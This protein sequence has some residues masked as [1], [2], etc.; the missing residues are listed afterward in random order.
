M[1]MNKIALAAALAF[2]GVAAHADITIGNERNSLTFY[3]VLD[4]GL[5]TTNHSL[6]EDPNSAS[7]N[8][9]MANAAPSLHRLTSFLP[10]NT[11]P[12][13]WG[14]KGQRNFDGGDSAGFVLESMINVNTG[15][16]PNGR[17]SDSLPGAGSMFNKGE[18]SIQGQMFDREASVW[19]KNDQYG[20]FKFGHMTTLMG[21][22]QFGYD[23]MSVGYAVSPLG[24]NGGW[25]A[26]A[27]TGD[28][29][30]DNSV[31]WTNSYGPFQAGLQYKFGGYTQGFTMGTAESAKIAYETAPFGVSLNVQ[32]TLDTL[33]VGGSTSTTACAAS[34]TLSCATPMSPNALSVSVANARAVALM[35]RYELSAQATLKG[36]F[37]QIHLQ[38]PTNAGSY[39]V[40]NIGQLS[41]LP[42]NSINIAPFAA[43]TGSLTQRMLWAGVNYKVDAKST[44]SAAYYRRTDDY[45]M[46][47][48]NNANYLSGKYEY[49]VDKDTTLY[50]TGVT[51]SVGT[52]VNVPT[53][54][55]GATWYQAAYHGLIP[56]TTT[57]TVGGVYRF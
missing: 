18:G 45:A 26:G 22:T 16:N 54:T 47:Q 4:L 5:G 34:A 1:K 30:W 21:D 43:S 12:S 29:R 36:G 53:V 8:S 39:T 35:A 20:L 57:F 50:V 15:T 24:M 14:F 3:G 23:P 2:A 27:Y 38:N 10:S 51:S 48:D 49:A 28:S 7:G 25:G 56:T 37:E 19:V 33:N 46:G 44:V 6:S 40:A 55:T 17:V 9:A 42:V 41:G 11:V 32:N 31:K 52:N 13:R